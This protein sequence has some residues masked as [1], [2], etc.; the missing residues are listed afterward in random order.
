MDIRCEENVLTNKLIIQGN[1]SSL[2]T[3]YISGGRNVAYRQLATQSSTYF[4][5]QKVFFPDLAVDGNKDSNF[6][7]G[8]CSHTISESNPHFRLTFNSVYV[9]Y[10]YILYNRDGSAG[11]RLQ[12]FR[13]ASWDAENKI[14]DSFKDQ[15]NAFRQIYY[16]IGTASK[17]IKSI[18]VNETNTNTDGNFVTLCELE[19]YG[20]CP[21]GKWSL[22]CTQNCP[23]SC[24]TSCDRDTGLCNTVFF[25][26]SDPP[27]CTALCKTGEWGINC[28]NI[29]STK[30][31]YLSCHPKT[32]ECTQGCLGY[33]DP[34]LCN[35]ECLKSTWGVNCS[36]SCSSH[37]VNNTCRATNGTCHGGC[38]VGY[39]LP[40]C[41]EACAA[42]SWGVS[43]TNKCSNSCLQLTCDSETGFCDTGYFGDD[44][45]KNRTLLNKTSESSSQPL[46][47]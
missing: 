46:K 39:K 4:E 31:A 21:P 44:G 5:G 22:P 12:Y 36:Q 29:C 30:C 42:G 41:T 32:G 2:C 26:F 15:H 25:G 13:L 35:T 1:V 10:Q 3:L 7:S 27:E 45:A 16:I 17:P 11:V 34:P 20:E 47:N 18:Y 19:A 23:T 37:C 6:L 14:V 40:D 28:R 38:K 33:S 8:S 43:C 24:P 9:I